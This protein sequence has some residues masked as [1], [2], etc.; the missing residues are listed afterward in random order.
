MPST[1]RIGCCSDY[2]CIFFGCVHS[3]QTSMIIQN[4]KAPL[5]GLSPMHSNAGYAS[6]TLVALSPFG[7]WPISNLTL[8][9]SLRDR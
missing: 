1:S 5:R 9:P 8:S 4:E 3:I 6:S 7:D 2:A